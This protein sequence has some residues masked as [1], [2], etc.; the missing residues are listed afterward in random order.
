[1]SSESK[2]QNVVRAAVIDQPGATPQARYFSGRVVAELRHM[3]PQGLHFRPPKDAQGLLLSPAADVSDARLVD[4]QGAVPSD[5]LA[6]G[7]GGLHLLGTFKVFLDSD[8]TLHLGQKDPTDYVAL[9][10]LVNARI[11][12]LRADIT[13]LIGA[14]AAVAVVA[15]GLAP[16]TSTTFNGAVLGVPAAAAS[17]AS[18]SVKCK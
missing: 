7:E 3:E 5:T 10:S 1:M 2:V 12:Q 13:T 6:S 4:A 8:G 15:D 16:G 14:T 18:T 11:T 17:V 9:A